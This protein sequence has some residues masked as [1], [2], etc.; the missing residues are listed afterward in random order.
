MSSLEKKNAFG[1]WWVFKITFSMHSTNSFSKSSQKRKQFTSGKK[2]PNLISLSSHSVRGALFF[3]SIFNVYI[4][5]TNWICKHWNPLH[6]FS[7]HSPTIWMKSFIFWCRKFMACACVRA[8]VRLTCSYARHL[9]SMD[10]ST[11]IITCT[12]KH[13]F[14]YK[15]TD[16]R[17]CFDAF[18][19]QDN[20]IVSA[21]FSD[22]FSALCCV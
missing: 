18:T 9:I 1:N 13:N 8:F 2:S 4:P 16:L 3:A 14:R 20:K 7:T 6:C 17:R 12:H 22:H 15:K 21:M 10:F 5:Y 11:D 19:Q